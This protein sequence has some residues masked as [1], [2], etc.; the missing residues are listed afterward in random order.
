MTTAYARA[1]DLLDGGT[2][3]PNTRR[4]QLI[5]DHP[6]PLDLQQRYDHTTVRTAA[7]ELVATRLRDTVTSR[8]GRLVI[9]VPPQQFKTSLCR[10]LCVWLLA[11]EPDGR[12]GYVSY[13]AQLARTSGRAVR[14]AIDTY[15]RDLGLT[16]ARGHADASD[17]S[18]A[19]GHRGGMLS[20]GVGGSLTG[21]SVDRALIIDDPVR[22]QQ[23]ADS[24]AVRGALHDWWSAVGR[25]RLAPGTPIIVVATRWHEDDLS[26]RLIAEGWPWLNIPALADGH[27]EDALDRS[28][29]TWLE[30]T[31]G[32]TAADWEATRRDIGERTFAAL[33]QGRP[34]PAEGGIFQR[35]WFN[36]HRLTTQPDGCLPPTVYVDPA[37]NAGDGDEAGI[38]V[39]ARHPPTQRALLLADLSAPMTVA[40][41]ARLALLTCVRWQAP[42]LA[43]EKSLAQL[44]QRITEAW[45]LLH[46]HATAIRACDGDRDRALA[47]LTRPD[48][49]PDAVQHAAVL[50]AELADDDVTGIL[51]FGPV[52]P[53]RRPITARGSKDLRMQLAAPLFE[54]GR[55]AIVGALPLFEHQ[56]ATWQVGQSSPDRVDTGVHAVL[57][58]AGAGGPTVVRRPGRAPTRVPI[59]TPGRSLP[60]AAGRVGR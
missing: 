21:R 42:T 41:W 22:N 35:A 16:L 9:S 6:T 48:D 49:T 52:G 30:S 12:I 20:V 26:G 39:A 56:A 32:H 33:Y 36:R 29:G 53:A 1:A 14:A 54:T 27:T 8:D 18:L 31:R 11:D 25:T 24:P 4:A 40:R 23:D 34:A 28:V 13:A 60:A 3:S 7:A 55:A 2:T 45:Q 15:G 19:G 50:L 59:R 57:D 46:L 10:W 47:R 5:T 51:A 38:F 37:D 43:W 44:A 58:L 17:W